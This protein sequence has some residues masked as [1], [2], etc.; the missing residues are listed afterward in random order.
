MI[1]GLFKS[2]TP[3]SRSVA[4]AITY[5]GMELA[6]LLLSASNLHADDN[7]PTRLVRCGRNEAETTIA[8]AYQ[9]PGSQPTMVGIYAKPYRIGDEKRPVMGPSKAVESMGTVTSTWTEF[10]MTE[11]TFTIK[12]VPGPDRYNPYQVVIHAPFLQN[13]SGTVQ[14]TKYEIVWNLAIAGENDSGHAS[15][16]NGPDSRAPNATVGPIV[17]SVTLSTNELMMIPHDARLA[18]DIEP[19]SESGYGDW[20]RLR[21]KDPTGA[22]AQTVRIQIT[23]DRGGN[24]GTAEVAEA[25]VKA[26]CAPY[27]SNSLEKKCEVQVLKKASG[28]IY[29]CLMTNAAFANSPTP[30]AAQFRYLFLGVFRI[31]DDVAFVIGNLSQKDDVD[32]R[33]MM[34]T[35]EGIHTLPIVTGSGAPA[36]QRKSV[37]PQ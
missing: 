25:E 35:L 13:V 17:N 31:S 32:F 28:N 26:V 34:E 27:L 11:V 7:P 29:Y 20:I 22:V 21:A 30:P 9:I 10:G 12:Q 6:V 23:D 3:S 2:R 8:F 1:Q 15:A 16:E 33:M 5:F 18:Y 36:I 19:D 24:L 14:G 37:S 4:L